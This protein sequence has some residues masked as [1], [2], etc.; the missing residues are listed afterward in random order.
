MD[1]LTFSARRATLARP[2]AE[3]DLDTRFR[4]LIQFPLRA[5][6]LRY[7]SAR[8]EESFDADSLMQTFGRLRLDVEN[9]IR[10]LVGFG[11]ARNPG[12][13]CPATPRRGRTTRRSTSC[14]T[15]SSKARND[16]HGGSVAVGSALPRDDRPRRE[17]ADRLRVDSHG[18]Q[19]RYLGAHPRSDRLR[20]RARCANDSRA[21]PAQDRGSSRRSTA[22][23]CPTRSSNRR[24]SATR[25]GVHGGARPQA[26]APRAGER[27]H[28][29]P[30]RN[31]RP[32]D[33]GAGKAAARPRGAP[34][35]A[36]RRQPLDSRR[37][38][39]H[40]GDS[41]ARPVRARQPIPRGSLLP[42]QRLFDTAAVAS[43]TAGRY[44]RAREPVSRS[45]LRGQ[46][47]ADRFEIVFARSRRSARGVSLAR[48]HPRA[49]N[50]LSRAALS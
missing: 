35:R 1:D 5:G 41:A 28:A 39:S 4:N 3:S 16:Q 40:F 38:P 23:R 33:R 46:R 37:F 11:V 19:V 34:L 31:R 14:S 48:Q 30:G 6:I 10:E 2:E 42:R 26:R 47:P 49:G 12:T 15:N 18:R 44:P 21:E 50:H 25:R 22:R 24:S 43:P 20:Q 45:L 17:D 8:P 7:L 32:V 36:P 13:P 9:C 29:I 27:G